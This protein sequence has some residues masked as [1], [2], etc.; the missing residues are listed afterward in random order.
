MKISH[1]RVFLPLLA[2][3]ALAAST[4]AQTTPTVTV[5]STLPSDIPVKG[6]APNATITDAAQFAW[7]EFIA[8]NWPAQPQTGAQNTRGVPNTTVNFGTDTATQPVV[9]ESYRGK[10]ET[11]PGNGTPPG[12]VNNPATDYGFDAAPAYDYGTATTPL[13]VPAC[14]SPAQPAVTTPALVNL[15]EVTQIGLDQIYAGVLPTSI[16]S[17]TAQN[18]NAQPQLIRFLA[19]GNRTFYDYVAANQY[20]SKTAAYTTAQQNFANAAAANTYPP[21][22]PTLTLPA[23]TVLVKAAWRPLASTESAANFHTKTVHFY[24][25][26]SGSNPATPCYREQ[27][28]ALIALHIIQKTPTAPN[29][30]FATFEYTSNILTP[31][32]KPVEDNN[33]K[34]NANSPAGD[35]MTPQLEYF[36]ADNKYYSPA[37]PKGTTSYPTGIKP[38]STVP[39]IVAAGANC[40]TTN[41]N[42]VYFQDLSD[43]ATPAVQNTVCVNKRYFEIPSQIQAVNAAAHTALSTYGAPGL[44]QNYKL[45]NVQWVPFDIGLIDKDANH[46]VSTF[47]L[48]NS[49]VETDNT[50]Q[51]F[52][53]GLFDGPASGSQFVKSGF[54]FGVPSDGVANNNY[55][56]PASGN[57]F[58]VNNMG[59]CMGCHGRAQRAGTDFSFTLK[60]GPVGTP[61]FG[62]LPATGSAAAD[63]AH[64]T[65][66]ID[67]AR[68]QS[69]F[70]LPSGH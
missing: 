67:K 52:F 60:E 56:A 39:A 34:P 9:W 35:G 54:E 23:G 43:A 61:E 20:W 25:Q 30:I 48:A 65:A 27:T 31:A 64:A 29:F 55:S 7:Q 47:S 37:F 2:A 21:K 10:V 50:L 24:D 53:G 6:G 63:A 13:T 22:S 17:P 59:G 57:Q 68:L 5:S 16:S 40:N 18:A 33:G 14:T 44:W 62:V 70:A 69:L 38:P 58:V 36:D 42:Q 41:N 32:G 19:K 12:Y 51:Q 46:Q 3:A 8:L 28:W 11:F 26:L 45:V 49:V 66:G 15:D 4:E 1:M